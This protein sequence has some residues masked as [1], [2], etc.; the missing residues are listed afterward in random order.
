MD[1]PSSLWSRKNWEVDRSARKRG[2]AVNGRGEGRGR[3]HRWRARREGKMEVQRAGSLREETRGCKQTRGGSCMFSGLWQ[4]I[5]AEY[6]WFHYQ[7]QNRYLTIADTDGTGGKFAVG[8]IF[9]PGLIGWIYLQLSFAPLIQREEGER[10]SIIWT[11]SRHRRPIKADS[12]AVCLSQ[13]LP[14]CLLRLHVNGVFNYSCLQSCTFVA[15]W[16]YPPGSAVVFQ[17]RLDWYR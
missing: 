16:P 5:P 3:L 7:C 14:V 15:I 13:C 1:T 4:Q 6:C 11:W 12:N 8:V 10:N 17:R 2:G 9:R